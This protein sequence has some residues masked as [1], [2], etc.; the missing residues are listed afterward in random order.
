MSSATRHHLQ[1]PGPMGFRFGSRCTGAPHCSQ[2]AVLIASYD[3]ISGVNLNTHE[4]QVCAEH[5]RRFA[6]KHGLGMPDTLCRK[7][8]E[9]RRAMLRSKSQ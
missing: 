5:A 8:R 7:L 2:P 6:A 3:Y 1:T 4:R 9:S